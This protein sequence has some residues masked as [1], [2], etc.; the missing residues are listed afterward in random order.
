MNGTVLRTMS[1]SDAWSAQ[2]GQD[3]TGEVKIWVTPTSVGSSA[4]SVAGPRVWLGDARMKYEIVKEVLSA[5]L[6]TSKLVC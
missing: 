1:F 6:G 5:S 2:F 3:S 4:K